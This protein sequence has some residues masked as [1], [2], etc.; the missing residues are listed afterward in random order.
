MKANV[1]AFFDP[2]TFT[3]TYAVWD[4]NTRDAVVIDPVLDYE[5][6]GSYTYTESIDRVRSKLEYTTVATSFLED[7]FTLGELR[8]IYEIVWGVDLDA[9]NFAR[10]IRAIPGFVAPTDGRRKTSGR[11]AQL[12]VAGDTHWM[13]PPMLRPA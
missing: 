13:L 8:D 11:S 10:K 1:E 3:L 9:A 7:A 6:V 4:P 2:R 12:Y 5:P